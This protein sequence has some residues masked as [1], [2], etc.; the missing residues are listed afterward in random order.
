M[1]DA[2]TSGT[3]GSMQRSIKPGVPKSKQKELGKAAA[4]AEPPARRKQSQSTLPVDSLSVKQVAFL[5]AYVEC[6]GNLTE[7]AK[8]AGVDRTSHG[9]NWIKKPVYAA[10]FAEAHAKACERIE[11]EIYRRGELGYEEPIVYKGQISKDADGKPL[12]VRKYSDTLLIFR[13]KK[14]IPEYRDHTSIEH[15]GQMTQR[16]VVAQDEDWYGNDAHR[17]PAQAPPTPTAGVTVAG[18]VQGGGV[19]P[20]LGQDGVGVAGDG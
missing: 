2:A 6:G 19:R 8:L 14:F 15:S 17:L 3:P 9:K 11:H 5:T 4:A 20:T 12:T 10:A 7:A 18:E 1:S 16:V 13:A